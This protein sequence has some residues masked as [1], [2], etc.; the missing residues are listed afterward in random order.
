MPEWDDIAQAA[1]S[2]LNGF[3]GDLQHLVDVNKLRTCVVIYE[4]ED[5]EG[6]AHL[7]YWTTPTTQYLAALG[8]AT[9]LQDRLIN[10]RGDLDE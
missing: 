9:W 8:A 7:S 5:E 4:T 1:D 6:T 3:V 10:N 2:G